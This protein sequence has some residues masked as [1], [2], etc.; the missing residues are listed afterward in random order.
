[1]PGGWGFSIW[2]S[3][4]WDATV[5]DENER[6]LPMW[7]LRIFLLRAGVIGKADYQSSGDSG[8]PAEGSGGAAAALYP[9]N[10]AEYVKPGGTLVYSTCTINKEN[11]RQ[12]ACC[13]CFPFSLQA[14]T[15]DAA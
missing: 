12:A 7:C 3:Q 13:P 4:V 10:A 14:L 5:P 8:E 6:A 15:A 1:M 9:I 11:E 2:K